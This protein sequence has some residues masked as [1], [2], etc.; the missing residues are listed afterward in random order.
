[1]ILVNFLDTLYSKLPSFSQ[2]LRQFLIKILP[3]IAL[4]FG[5][6]ITFASIMDIIGTPFLSVLSPGEGVGIFQKLMIVNV[7]GVFEGVFMLFAF[8]PLKRKQKKGWRLLFWSQLLW[9]IAALISLSP[10]FI[11]GFIFFYPLFQ[12][13]ESY[14]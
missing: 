11:L 4:I 14:R 5:L 9:I 2:E 13:R 10:S 8:K 7:I 6:L 12:V 3:W 1:M